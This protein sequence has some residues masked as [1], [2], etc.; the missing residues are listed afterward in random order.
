MTPTHPA[1]PS[2]PIECGLTPVP[3]SFAA[4][5]P[6]TPS[7]RSV[8]AAPDSPCLFEAERA[9]LDSLLI[10]PRV[11]TR[12]RVHRRCRAPWGA[13]PQDRPGR[14]RPLAGQPSH[15]DRYAAGRPQSCRR[16]RPIA[17]ARE[18]GPAG[19]AHPLHQDAGRRRAQ[20]PKDG[21]RTGQ[22]R[23]RIRGRQ[24]GPPR[25]GGQGPVGPAGSAAG[26]HVGRSHAC[27]FAF[28]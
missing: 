23:H 13:S 14:A 6:P 15:R 9:L 1:T 19:A 25:Y 28:V 11:A 22:P 26:P 2:H 5:I 8:P 17:N 3:P 18:R 20:C 12:A 27:S 7:R 24:R 4:R 21:P 16:A 10:I